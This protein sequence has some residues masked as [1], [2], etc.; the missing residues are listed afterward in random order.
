[1]M[2]LFLKAEPSPDAPY[3]LL[4]VTITESRS[5][6]VTLYSGQNGQALVLEQN[7]FPTLEAAIGRGI[8]IREELQKNGWRPHHPAVARL[9]RSAYEATLA[10]LQL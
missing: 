8:K 9:N 6:W 4:F 1:M 5:G 3:Q 10:A 2:Y 7:E